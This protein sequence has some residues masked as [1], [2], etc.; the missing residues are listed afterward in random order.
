MIL[1]IKN[2]I[3]ISGH[4]LGLLCG[5]SIAMLYLQSESIEEIRKSFYICGL[6]LTVP[7][8]FAVFIYSQ[9]FNL[10]SHR[11]LSY[12]DV[13]KIEEIIIERIKGFGRQIIVYV[14]AF[15]SV[16]PLPY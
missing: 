2:F 12:T 6:T 13:E 3:Q 4:F 1:Y 15:F 14:C 9:L 8:T 10:S 11:A 5:L 7:A 16:L